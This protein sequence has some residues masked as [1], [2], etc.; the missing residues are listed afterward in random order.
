MELD[1]KLHRWAEHYFDN[2]IPGAEKKSKDPSTKVACI[3]TYEDYGIATICFNG[4]PRGVEDN[5]E[6]VP[7]R[8]ERPLKYMYT[9]HAEANGIALACK[10]GVCFNNGKLFIKWHPCD[11]CAG[12]I[13]QSGIKDVIIDTDSKEYNDPNLSGGRWRESIEVAKIIFNEAKINTYLFK[14]Q[15]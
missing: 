2:I 12:Q 1:E 5:P 6:K 15:K 4:F 8:Y 11:K 3:Y 7:E 10:H 14:R 13:V 9:V